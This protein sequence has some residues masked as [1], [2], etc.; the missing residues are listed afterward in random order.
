M[1]LI[2]SLVSVGLRARA[3]EK[4][5]DK[6]EQQT[7]TAVGL[8]TI[9]MSRDLKNAHHLGAVLQSKLAKA[10]VTLPLTQSVFHT[11]THDPSWQVCNRHLS[12]SLVTR[13]ERISELESILKKVTLTL[14]L[15]L[16]ITLTLTP[17][18][19]SIARTWFRRIYCKLEGGT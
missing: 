10:E 7:M 5:R 14:T 11:L 9:N 2:H 12:S 13:V 17:T 8:A 1:L 15:T 3:V 18:L 19:T 6:C 16:V 4:M